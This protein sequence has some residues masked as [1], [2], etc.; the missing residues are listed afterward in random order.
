MAVARTKA[1]G[2][3]SIP[4]QKCEQSLSYTHACNLVNLFQILYRE[5]IFM[6]E[7]ESVHCDAP[8]KL[9]ETTTLRTLNSFAID[10]ISIPNAEDLFWYIARNVVGRLN[11]VDCVIYQANE[12]QTSLVQAAAFGEK[13][14]FGRSIVNPLKIPFGQGITGQVAQ[15]REAIIIDDLLT[16]ENYIE[17][18]QVARS[19]ICVPIICGNRVLGAIDSE[20]PSPGAFGAAELEVLTTIAAMTCAK[21]ELLAETQRSNRRYNDLV[22][23]HAQLS[24]ETTNRKALE[25]ELFNARKLEAVGRLTGRFAHEFN[26]LLTVVS[27]NLEFLDETVSGGPFEDSLRDAQKAASRGATLIQSML[28]YSQRTRLSAEITNLNSAVLDI[29]AQNETVRLDLGQNLS[30]INVDRGV[31]EISLLHLIQN[32]ET[33]MPPGSI[34]RIK[35][36]EITYSLSDDQPLVSALTPGRYIRLSVIDNGEGI[37]TELLEQIFDPFFTTRPTGSGT[38]LGLSMTLGF[39]LQSGGSVG[40]ESAVGQGVTLQ[41]YFPVISP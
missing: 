15:T 10:L 5:P 26:N 7:N 1:L 21:L 8:K 12:E 17:D 11:F 38:G 32:A 13:N 39:M 25:T 2:K 34:V 41:L 24:Q 30:D 28:T 3:R 37:P 20:H 29:V 18:T 16:D 31:F 33:A 40:I 19:E 9:D 22:T 27:G 23:A 4:T 6:P 14:P 35:T 36:E